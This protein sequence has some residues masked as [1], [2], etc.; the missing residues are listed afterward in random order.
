[1]HAG[2]AF[3]LITVLG[4]GMEMLMLNADGI[5]F[6]AGRE[7]VN[8]RARMSQ[9][10][11]LLERESLFREGRNSQTRFTQVVLANEVNIPALQRTEPYETIRDAIPRLA[12]APLAASAK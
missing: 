2:C 11:G 7:T 5:T 3:T 9:F 4:Q 12:R 8:L 1:M 10:G 6:A